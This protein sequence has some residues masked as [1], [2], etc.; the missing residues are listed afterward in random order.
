MAPP[1]RSERQGSTSQTRSEHPNGPREEE[2]VVHELLRG[3]QTFMQQAPAP[4][5]QPERLDRLTQVIESFRRLQPAKLNGCEGAFA[6]EEWVSG[7]ERIFKFMDVSETQKVLCA[8][9]QMVEDA[10]L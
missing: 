9:F 3:L 5:P 8:T 10:G 6:T 2:N 1:R 4:A 7:L